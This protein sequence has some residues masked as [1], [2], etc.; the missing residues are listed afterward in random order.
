MKLN[1][2]AA[3][4]LTGA[5]ATALTDLWSIVRQRL[6]GVA[7]PNF[8]LVG[9]WVAHLAHGRLHHDSIAAS[10]AARNEHAL[11]WASH[12]LIGMGFACI[13]PALRGTEWFCNPTPGPAL[14]VGIATVAAPLLVMQPAMGAGFFA[15]R[16]ARPASARIQSLLMHAVFGLGLYLAATLVSHF[17]PGE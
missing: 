6:F 17:L 16:T 14:L 8:L 13:L 11:G 10:P 2:I 7:P 3:I 15:S 1:S 9:R 5:G 12:Y 4:V